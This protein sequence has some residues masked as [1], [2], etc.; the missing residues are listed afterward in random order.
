MVLDS[1]GSRPFLTFP[2]EWIVHRRVLSLGGVAYA[3]S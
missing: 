2:V 1:E 3:R